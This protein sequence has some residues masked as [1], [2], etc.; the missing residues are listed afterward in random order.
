[1]EVIEE[2]VAEEHD[3]TFV[4]MAAA[5]AVTAEKR[6]FVSVAL[7]AET[8]CFHCSRSLC[9]QRRTRSMGAL[10]PRN[11]RSVAEDIADLTLDAEAAVTQIFDK[12]C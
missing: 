11:L 8:G 12:H 1:M 9:F 7:T 3:C 5:L 4:V 6:Y 2:F 10:G